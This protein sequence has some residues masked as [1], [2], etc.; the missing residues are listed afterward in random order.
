MW[1]RVGTRIIPTP[2]TSDELFQTSDTVSQDGGSDDVI[3]QPFILHSVL[4]GHRARVWDVCAVKWQNG[5]VLVSA[6]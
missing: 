2:Q 6:G 3:D 5:V 1:R 4:K